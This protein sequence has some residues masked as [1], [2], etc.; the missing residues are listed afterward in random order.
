TVGAAWAIAESGESVTV[1]PDDELESALRPL[2][3]S[4]L[5]LPADVLDILA[6]LG[7]LTID[8]LLRMERIAL[9]ERFAG[10]LLGRLDQ[11]FGPTPEVIVPHRPPPEYRPA[12]ELDFPTDRREEIDALTS[13]LIDRIV[14]DLRARGAGVVRLAVQFDCVPTAEDRHETR[15][16]RHETQ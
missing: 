13:Q 14:A 9:A 4:T 6:Q 10:Q 15:D 2:S 5:R 16:T 8:Q 12:I 7:V 11:A 3:V 1:V